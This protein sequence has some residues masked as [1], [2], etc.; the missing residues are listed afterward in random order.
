MGL[1]SPPTFLPATTFCPHSD[2]IILQYCAFGVSGDVQGSEMR[3]D[4]DC[5]RS[6]KRA[7]STSPSDYVALAESARLQLWLQ[8]VD[9]T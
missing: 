8:N 9:V 7:D 3:L 1:F 5:G 2:C 6:F 4:I